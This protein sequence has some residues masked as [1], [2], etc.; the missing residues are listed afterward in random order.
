MRLA[1]AWL[2]HRDAALGACMSLSASSGGMQWVDLS[3]RS[4][5]V[6][7]DIRPLR[8]ELV[9]GREERGENQ[10]HHGEAPLHPFSIS[11]F[12]ISVRCRWSSPRSSL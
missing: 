9:V 5:C 6:L 12:M 3:T 2:G 4:V 10:A 1:S 11:A 7:D 8:I